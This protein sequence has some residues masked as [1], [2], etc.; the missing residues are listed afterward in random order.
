[1]A[2]D[3]PHGAIRRAL[4]LL[5]VL[6]TGAILLWQAFALLAP[7]GPRDA[8]G[9]VK[10][11]DFVHF[12]TLGVVARSGQLATLYENRTLNETMWRVVPEARP[13]VFLPLYGPQVAAAFAPLAALP[14]ER[15]VHVWLVV[16]LL[17]YGA[18]AAGDCVARSRL[19]G[20]SRG[21][22]VDAGAQPGTRGPRDVGADQRRGARGIRDRVVRVQ[23]PARVGRGHCPGTPLVQ[24]DAGGR[25]CRAAP[26]HQ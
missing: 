3:L 2:G 4:S 10:G 20:P 8:H 21:G 24:T 11:H 7:A 14:Y 13:G 5:P 19:G 17:L 23:P 26:R 18:A 25:R 22:R 6:L 15:A 12:Y 1:M 9:I 16:S